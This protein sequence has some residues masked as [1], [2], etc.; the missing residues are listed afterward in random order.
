V[1]LLRSGPQ[2]VAY[3][4]R[5]AHFGVPLASRQ[6]L[7][8]FTPH[9]SLTCGVHYARF[10]WSDGVCDRGDCEGEGLI[11]IPLDIDAQG[12]LRIASP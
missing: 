5:C 11:P 9:V 6:D 7:L 2:V 10:R 12:A 1:L 8:Q 4:N 3:V